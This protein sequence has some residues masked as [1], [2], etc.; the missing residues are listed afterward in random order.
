LKIFSK[1]SDIKY[2]LPPKL[3]SNEDLVFDNPDWRM[4]DIEKKTGIKYRYICEDV[5]TSKDIALLA[6]E[7]IFNSNVRRNDIDF[8]IVVTESP[9]YIAPAMSCDIQNSLGL[10]TSVASFDVNLGCSGFVYGLMIADSILCANNYRN[11]LLVCVDTYSKYISSNDR[12]CRPL[13]SD[14]ASATLITASTKKTIGPFVLGTDGSGYTD[15]M[16]KNS[17]TIKNIDTERN[18]YFMN[19][20]AVFMFTMRVVPKAVNDLLIKEK[21]NI[22]DIDLFVFHQASKLVIDNLKRL[23]KLSNE[24]VFENYQLVGNTVSSSIPIALSQAIDTEKIKKG[25]LVMLVG[26]GV[27]LSWGAT[28]IRYNE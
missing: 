16:V 17:G 25:S 2:Y 18:L 14:A 3:L 19:G 13:F 21:C 5:Q 28:I 27:G 22:E 1:I 7:K 23:L 10:E 8:L 20:S 12:T 11:G 26:F 15:L 6:C 4:E 24:K 9:E